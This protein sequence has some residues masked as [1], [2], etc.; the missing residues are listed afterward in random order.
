ML[1]AALS[2]FTQLKNLT[3]KYVT[4]SNDHKDEMRLDLPNLKNLKVLHLTGIHVERIKISPVSLQNLNII[5]VSGSLRGLLSALPDCQHLTDL[6]ITSLS[7]EQDVKLLADVLP[8]LT[9]VR[10]MRYDGWQSDTGNEGVVRLLLRCIH[11]FKPYHY[12]VAQA[13]T[14]MTGL[15]RLYIWNIDMGDLALSLTPMMTHIKYVWLWY[16]HMTANSWDEFIASL[17]TIQHG[18]DISLTCTNIHDDSVSAVQS[19]PHFKVT[20]DEK[21]DRGW[22]L[23][24]FR[25]SKL[26][27]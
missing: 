26:S 5:Y 15:E 7:N 27:S 21:E 4:F 1:Q 22:E 24:G 14:L 3:L 12:A 10:E 20:K 9:Q 16:V 8:R 11:H 2:S 6:S 25:F 23:P 13:A 19:S 18:F 17:L